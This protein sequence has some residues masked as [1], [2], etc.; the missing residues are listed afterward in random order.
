M[1]RPVPEPD[2]Y[3][4]A[5]NRKKGRKQMTEPKYPACEYTDFE[6]PSDDM[7]TH[8]MGYASKLVKT[9]KDAACCYCGTPIKAGDYAVAAK[10]FIEQFDGNKPFRIHY[11]MDCVDEE[12]DVINGKRSREE[13]YKSWESRLR[14]A[15]PPFTLKT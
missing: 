14:P 8:I 11:C 4:Y 6:I 15:Q 12:L 10:G 7:E 1:E 3:L 2:C 9:R 5:G 13:C